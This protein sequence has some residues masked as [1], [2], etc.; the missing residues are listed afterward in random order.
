ME[1][2]LLSLA[3]GVCS[4][5]IRGSAHAWLS[6]V[7][8]PRTVQVFHRRDE[9]PDVS[10]GLGFIQPFLF[11]DLVQEVATRTQLH[12]QVVAVLCLQDVQELCDVGVSDHLLDL[13]L[14][15]QVFGDVG[16]FLGSFLIDDLDSYLR[17]KQKVW[18]LSDT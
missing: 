13:P 5:Q 4:V 3:R 7:N 12:D 15:T 1:L 8:H 10:A 17:L 9:L 11:V 18:L 14:S 16:V 6:P 2:Q